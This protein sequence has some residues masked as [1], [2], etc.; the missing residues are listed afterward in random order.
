MPS[1][2]FAKACQALVSLAVA[3]PVSSVAVEVETRRGPEGAGGPKGK[4]RTMSQVSPAAGSFPRFK[5]KASFC[6]A[7]AVAS[8]TFTCEENESLNKYQ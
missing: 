1:L 4:I 3:L 8:S 5:S 7:L 2:L 6:N